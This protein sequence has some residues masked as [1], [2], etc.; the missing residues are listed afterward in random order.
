MPSHEHIFRLVGNMGEPREPRLNEIHARGVSISA[1]MLSQI[2][3]GDLS[4]VMDSRFASDE[5]MDADNALLKDGCYLNIAVAGAKKAQGRYQQT[6]PHR[7]LSD[8]FTKD[9]ASFLSMDAQ[10]LRRRLRAMR[11]DMVMAQDTE[12]DEV[13]TNTFVNTVRTFLNDFTSKGIIYKPV[14]QIKDQWTKPSVSLFYHLLYQGGGR[15][16]GTWTPYEMEVLVAF[17]KGRCNANNPLTPFDKYVLEASKKGHL[18]GAVDYLRDEMGIEVDRKVL[19]I[20]RNTLV[21]GTHIIPQ[22]EKGK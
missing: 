7:L 10:V 9:L 20:H 3:F 4:A 6:F 18:P 19:E 13:F 12:K 2:R 22:P 8:G 1:G 5:T 15:S 11:I 21:Y 17:Y 16:L 14:Q